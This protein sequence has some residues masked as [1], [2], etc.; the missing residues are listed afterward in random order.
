MPFNDAPEYL[1]GE[2]A[3]DD[4][5]NLVVR[6][7]AR[8]Q[9]QDWHNIGARSAWL[10]PESCEIT[11]ST[12][13]PRDLGACSTRIVGENGQPRIALSHFIRSSLDLRQ[14]YVGSNLYSG[15]GHDDQ[16]LRRQVGIPAEWSATGRHHNV[17]LRYEH[18]R[19]SL[20]C[21]ANNIL[22]HSAQGRLRRFRLQMQVEAVGVEG[23]FEFRFERLIYRPL[24][25][26]KSPNLSVLNCWLPEFSPTFV[27]YSH[28][29]KAGVASVSE[30][31][32]AK[33]VR[34]TGD[35][36][37]RGGDS[38]IERVSKCI[39]KASFVIVF[40]SPASVSS[41]WVSKELETALTSQLSGEISLRV[42]PVV[43]IPCEIPPFLR[44]ILRYDLTAAD[45]EEQLEKLLA[46]LSY[47]TRW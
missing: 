2:V 10:E 11:V 15:F 9:L 28:S 26:A 13:T 14:K 44:G 17:T 46:T 4:F 39:S 31:L 42:V 8:D 35:W 36:E 7:E 29:D 43:I 41:G 12:I 37:F 23:E 18:E 6:G 47:K 32:R 34:L 20:S 24:T 25:D 40:L 38:L 22:V 21:Y 16:G 27:S 3:V 33:G 30:W 19:E 1:A 5:D 45:R